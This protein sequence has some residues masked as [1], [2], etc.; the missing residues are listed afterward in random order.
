MSATLKFFMIFSIFLQISK[1][2]RILVVIN[3]PFFS[4]NVIYS[5]LIKDLAARGH[6]LTVYSHFNMNFEG[7]SNITSY[8]FENYAIERFSELMVAQKFEKLH[9]SQ[10]LYQV[11][12]TFL[13]LSKSNIRNGNFRRL[14]ENGQKN[15]FEL[16]LVESFTG[17]EAILA[18]IYDCPVILLTALI[19]QIMNSVIGSSTFHPSIAPEYNAIYAASGHL[20]FAQRLNSFA[21]YMYLCSF[22][23]Y[24][25]E[26][27]TLRLAKEDFRYDIGS[28]DFIISSIDATLSFTSPLLMFNLPVL[29]NMHHVGF[30]HIDPVRELPDTDVKRFL[31]SSSSGAILMSMGSVI[32]ASFLGRQRMQAFLDAFAQLP[33]NFLLKTDDPLDNLPK[34]VKSVKWLPQSD[35]L[36]HP[37]LKL[38]ITHG[39]L[40]SIEES[41]VHRVPMLVVPFAFD[42][43]SNAKYVVHYGIGEE[44]NINEL[45]AGSLA[46]AISNLMNCEKYQR[47]AAE[48]G[49]RLDNITAVSREIAVFNVEKMIRNKNVAKKFLKLSKFKRIF[50]EEYQVDCYIFTIILCFCIY[51]LF[52]FINF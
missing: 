7:Y 8:K 28:I 39:G 27:E 38:F 47:N 14:F 35:V 21:N 5:Q 31:D 10:S 20:T 45:T 15:D 44:Y 49:Q 33:Y 26:S 12:Y 19:F 23:Q 37:N 2:S 32:K 42:Q 1:S 41:V 11:F 48:F 4:H 50:H 36:A 30:I 24:F 29:P 16:M 52:K 17:V 51:K 6:H 43:P 34:N 9:W 18:K 13:D 46:D 3:G 25:H 22:F 40:R